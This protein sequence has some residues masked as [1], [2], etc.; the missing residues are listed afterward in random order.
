[1]ISTSPLRYPGGKARFTNFVLSAIRQSGDEARVFIEPFCGGAGV[2]I[3]LL[4]SDDIGAIALNDV[5]PLVA[6]FWQVVFGK[7]ATDDRDIRWLVSAIETANLSIDEWRRLRASS[8][9]SIREAA[10]KCIYLNRTSFNG[11]LHNAGPIG[12]WEQKI[13]TLDVR[14]NREK[15]TRRILALYAQREK[16]VRVGNENWRKF[17]ASTGRRAGGY[18][19]I[20]PPYYHKAHKLYGHFFNHKDHVAMRDCLAELDR[21]WMLSYDDAPEIRNLYGH[22]VGVHGRVIDQT[23]SAHPIGGCSF[24]GRELFFSNRILPTTYRELPH[25]GMSVVGTLC[26]VDAPAGPVR[27]PILQVAP[28]A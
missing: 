9:A 16:V 13:R 21:P 14:F 7:T 6:S 11:I 10:F 2:S 15:L 3:A 1:M 17:C 18:L 22:L 27:T 19:Y 4:E 20:D 26:T 23:Y 8:P 28:A 12:G 5:D 24:V 25:K